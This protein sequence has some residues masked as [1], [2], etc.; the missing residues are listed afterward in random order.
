LGRA[1]DTI[2]GDPVEHPPEAWALG[3]RCVIELII[4][5]RAA[6]AAAAGWL[7]PA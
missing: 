4:D 3:N 5:D 7:F 1:A 6:I 2:A